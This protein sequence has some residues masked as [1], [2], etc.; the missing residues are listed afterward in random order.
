[1]GMADRISDWKIRP[2]CNGGF[3][4]NG[5][6]HKAVVERKEKYVATKLI[7]GGRKSLNQSKR[8]G[9]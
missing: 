6:V 9:E 2:F 3:R 7:V 1:M 8:K 5:K 4:Q